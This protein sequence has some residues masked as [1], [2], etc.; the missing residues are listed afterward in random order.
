MGIENL[1]FFNERV[2][3]KDDIIR[4]DLKDSGG[5]LPPEQVKE[6]MCQ[7]KP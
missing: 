5:Y 2:I 4:A 7:H 1:I 6:F 3:Q